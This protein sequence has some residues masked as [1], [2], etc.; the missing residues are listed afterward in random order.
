MGKEAQS[1]HEA[2]NINT[3]FLI[4][5]QEMKSAFFI[6]F[7]LLLY[8]CYGQKTYKVTE[9]DLQFIHPEKG[10]VIKKKDSFY[11]L[12]I[13]VDRTGNEQ[14]IKLV[15]NPI[16]KEEAE[17]FSKKEK[18]VSYDEIDGGYD[19]KKLQKLQFVYEEDGHE[20]KLC[21]FNPG[22][23]AS[24]SNK[25]ED[26]N[27]YTKLEEF[28]PYIFIQFGKKKIICTYDNEY[29]C[30]IPAKNKINLFELYSN[31]VPEL[32]TE[33]LSLTNNEVYEF[34]SHASYDLE[35]AFFKTDTLS[36]KKVRLKN[37]NNETLIKKSYDSIL[38]GP[39]IKCYNKG[40][41]DLYNLALKKLNK[42][43]LKAVKQNRG[44]IQIIENNRLKLIDWTGAEIKKRIDFPI[45]LFDAPEREYFYETSIIKKPH[46][47]VRLR[48]LGSFSMENSN[49]TIDSISLI[50]TN[51]IKD[52]YFKNQSTD[53]I[54]R[55]NDF[56]EHLVFDNKARIS[57]FINFDY[58]TVWFLKD[59][60]TFG[61]DFLGHFIK[62][63]FDSEQHFTNYQN[64]QSVSYK[65]PYYKIKK[66]N[67]YQFFPIQKEFRYKKLDDFQ[68]NFARFE[69]PDGQKGWLDLKGKEYLD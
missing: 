43:K 63:D 21:Q 48:N 8:P 64:L 41:I 57:D 5:T 31:Y 10:I 39:I 58:E 60:G 40:S 33:K 69:L 15:L 3:L 29:L 45:V 11:T 36:D 17:T 53:T 61:M 26:E 4:E 35:N 62:S 19:F 46:F 27:I 65:Y 50:N 25:Q 18:T 51:G 49:T 52:I 14:K 59:D 7:L 47:I 37:N 34:S 54:G 12:T 42:S 2:L 66:G 32:K 56:T 16:K 23:F 20:Y 30:L 9:G 68:G 22:Y 55:P 13:N 1:A 6:F 44:S 67:L 28:M 38:L 24:F